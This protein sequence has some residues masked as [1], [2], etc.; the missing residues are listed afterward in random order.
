MS[1]VHVRAVWKSLYRNRG[2]SFVR[3]NRQ[4]HGSSI[5]AGIYRCQLLAGAGVHENIYIGLYPTDQGVLI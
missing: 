3:L 1:L 4:F 5:A 2:P